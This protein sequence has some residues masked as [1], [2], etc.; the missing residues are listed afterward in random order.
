M[1]KSRNK[2]SE[3]QTCSGCG[4]DTRAKNGICSLCW[5]SQTR[6][7]KDSKSSSQKTVEIKVIERFLSGRRTERTIVL[8]V[9]GLGS[10]KQM[11]KLVQDGNVFQIPLGPTTPGVD[12]LYH[13][14]KNDDS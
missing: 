8:D 2:P 13:G 7:L 11:V 3:I 9:I 4:R 14:P 10:E 1:A 12:K 5:G 6:N